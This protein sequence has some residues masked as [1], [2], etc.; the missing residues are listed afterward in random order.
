[1]AVAVSKPRAMSSE[2]ICSQSSW[3]SP[4][5]SFER[6][7]IYK[8]KT[9]AGTGTG[10]DQ[11]RG[12][13]LWAYVLTIK[14]MV[15]SKLTWE[16]KIVPGKNHCRYRRCLWAS[17]GPSAFSSRAHNSSWWSPQYLVER[18]TIYKQK[19][20]TSTGSGY[21]QTQLHELWAHMLTI[22]PFDSSKLSWMKK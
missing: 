22:K 9:T 16:N 10:C 4:Q 14:Q 12:H 18:E 3:W 7:K 19:T 2:L 11:A 21:E 15:S 20:T 6:N 13:Q 5:N 8:Q 1:M 17:L